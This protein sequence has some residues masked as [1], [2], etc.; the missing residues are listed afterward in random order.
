VA[1]A[2]EVATAALFLAC[3]DSSFVSG[4]GL[5]VDGAKSAGVFNADRYR[6]DF[7]LL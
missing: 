3:D 2:E 6:L 4:V 7:E 1:S 5:P